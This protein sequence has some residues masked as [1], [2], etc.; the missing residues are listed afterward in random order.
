MRRIDLV[1]S[2]DRH[3]AAMA[4]PVVQALRARGGFSPRVLSLCELRG[5]TTPEG[6]LREAG[7]EVVRLVPSGLRRSPSSGGGE[8]TA[9]PSRRTRALR[10]LVWSL[11]L[12]PHLARAWRERPAVTVVPN[13]FAFPYDRLADALRKR[14]LP[15]LLLQ[16]GIRFPLPAERGPRRYGSGGA[17]VIAVW[18]ESSRRH[19]AALGVPTERIHV[20]GNPRLAPLPAPVAERRGRG[21]ALLLA[22]N[23]IDDQGYCTR[24]EKLALVARFVAALEG[25]LAR[26]ELTLALKLHARESADEYRTAMGPLSALVEVETDTPLTALLESHDAAVVLASSVGVEALRA[27]LGLGVLEIP[28]H[29]FAWEY[30]ASGAA[31]GLAWDAAPMPEQVERLFDR[32]AERRPAAEA[33]LRDV[34]APVADPT[35]RI[36]DLIETLSHA[37]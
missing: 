2:N 6:L 24:A 37:D 3:H 7:A 27:G 13:D 1:V 32:R 25:A 8:A 36:V 11:L 26:R 15:F 22:T 10:R 28:G 29:G 35:G 14:R 20:T 19:F 16:E 5:L 21:R 12:R 34:L 23:P 30:V 31:E 9:G 17:D 18:G 33:F 4:V